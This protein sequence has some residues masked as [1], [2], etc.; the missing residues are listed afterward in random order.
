MIGISLILLVIL[1][2][3]SIGIFIKVA[4]NRKLLDLPN[5]R[6][7]HTV[8]TPRG[9]GVVF[10]ILWTSWLLVMYWLGYSTDD[11]LLPL[12]PPVFLLSITSFVDDNYGLSARIRFIAQLLA[13]GYGVIAIGG[14]PELNL[15]FMIVPWG[16]VGIIFAV[17]ALLWSINLYNFMDGIDGIAA[18][19]ALFVFG[20]GGSFIW[21]A[22]GLVL[23]YIIWAMAA[24]IVGFLLWNKPPAKVFMGDVGSTLLGF[25]V[26]MFALLGEIYYQVP[27]LLWLILYGVFWFDATITL[28][29][30]VG[31]GDIWYQAHRLHAYQRLQ[32][33]HWSHQKILLWVTLV[34]IILAIF[35]CGAFYWQQYMLLWLVASIILLV[36]IYMLIE[37]VQPMYSMVKLSSSRGEHSESAGRRHEDGKLRKIDN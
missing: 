19:E 3:F 2:Y 23:A 20:V 7:S 28:V 15:G 24:I 33:Q 30:R 11:Y 17:I 16:W 27:W 10:P 9:G 12:L 34:N 1:T 22:G 18:I 8:P 36:I 35:A 21:Q 13:A 25:L 31:H 37:R 14:L 4:I 32:L 5:A 6:S 26:V 29:R